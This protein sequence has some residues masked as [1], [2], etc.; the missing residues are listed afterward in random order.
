MLRIKAAHAHA[1]KEIASQDVPW[2]NDGS[3][4]G[5]AELS[6]SDQTKALMSLLCASLDFGRFDC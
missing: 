1:V 5:T 6:S 2:G 4:Q 3:G